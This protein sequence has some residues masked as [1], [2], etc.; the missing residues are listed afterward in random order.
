[1]HVAYLFKWIAHLHRVSKHLK[2]IEIC[3]ILKGNIFRKHNIDNFTDNKNVPDK[4][5]RSYEKLIRRCV[6]Q[7]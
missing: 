2:I 3:G 4:G 6:N 7:K 5:D 1:M